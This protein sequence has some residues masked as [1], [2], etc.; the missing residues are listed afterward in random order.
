M[1][2]DLNRLQ[3][4]CQRFIIDNRISADEKCMEEGVLE[5]APD[6]LMTLVEI[7]G[8]YEY[9]DDSVDEE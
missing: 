7:L 5:N 2:S 1:S 6:L 3:E 8:Y 4:V 9:P